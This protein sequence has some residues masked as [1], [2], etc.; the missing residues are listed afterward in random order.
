MTRHAGLMISAAI[1]ALALAST[2]AAAQTAPSTRPVAD[3]REAS[4]D[5]GD[6]VVTAQKREQTLLD[7]PQSVSVVSGAT[8]ERQQANEFADYLKNVPG[9]QLNQ[10]TPG[11]G[12]LVLRGINSGG[13]A[14]TVAV[15]LDETPFGSSSG[16]A[17][18][19][20][21]AA[22]FETFDVARIEVLRGPQ[23]TLYGA[24]S[25]GGL[26][27]FVTNAP[28]TKGVEARGRAS[29][30]TTEGGA[31]SY[32]GTAVINLPLGDTLA[33]RASGTYRRDGGYID[34]I[35]TAGSDRQRN[36]NEANSYG[37]RA[38][39][40][41][42]PSSAFSV[43][44]SAVLQNINV[45]APSLVESDASS[46]KPLY[47]NLTLSQYVPAFSDIRYRLYN[48]LIE[49]DFGFATLTSS[50]SYGTQKLA[51]RE[52]F[53]ANLSEFLR[54]VLPLLGAPAL[55][56]NEIF[57]RQ[58]TDSEKWTQEVRLAS[59]NNDS[60]EWLLGGY[61][62]H[63]KAQILQNIIAVEPGTLTP[64]T[65]PIPFGNVD[66]RSRY[67]EY[68]GF[69]NATI[70][71]GHA[72]S[73]DLGGR[74]SHNNQ[75][76][77]QT[78]SGILAGNVATNSNIRSSDNVFT[79]AVAPRLKLGENASV[80][81]RVSRGYRPGGPN[82]ISPNAP[83]GTPTSFEPDTVMSYEG[84]VKA[85]T[86][87]RTFAIEAAGYHI[88][89]RRIQLLAVVNGIGVNVNGPD[90]T[91]NGAEIT[92]TLRP[93]PGFVTS[94][95]AAYTDAKLRGDTDPLLLG[96]SDG[97]R[98]PFTPKYSISVNADYAWAVGS[99]V[100]ATIGGSIRS[101]SNQ[102]GN[103]DPS[104]LAAYQ[105]FARVPA[106]E[107]VDLRAGLDFGRFSVDVYAKNLTNARGVTSVAA[108]TA[109]NQFQRPNGAIGTGIIR[110]RT[111][112]VS[113]TAG[114]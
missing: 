25:L 60:F 9:L 47:G 65:Y 114:F 92:A 43:R 23:G 69:A 95:N 57:S 80:Y 98:L 13:V 110:P 59:A 53:T 50:T 105:R 51:F 108:L 20:T 111:I 106:Y 44:L 68:A 40:L 26:L 10:S 29:V 100:D 31:I 99:G 36:I 87:D 64:L 84:G 12:R 41:W 55:P 2:T 17:N 79:F 97:D 45:D 96:G 30:E 94:I 24:N 112:G 91:V 85:E 89:W 3:A 88:D 104:Y 4:E 102:S 27:K 103:F 93:T 101:L 61:Y 46:L 19:G 58:N 90:A 42:Q 52:D 83:A 33:F 66:L 11:Q 32:K 38:S 71:F 75:R 1:S 109:S 73:I 56:A 82:V 14:S 54:A 15:Y 5:S 86:A 8:L 35:G 18:G 78:G 28:S 70:H 62:T 16:L 49:Y 81:A 34:S 107:V 74:Y 22:D 39:L 37:G 76:A 21:L 48:G 6:I 113:L 72:V 67:A 77:D 7:V 63:E